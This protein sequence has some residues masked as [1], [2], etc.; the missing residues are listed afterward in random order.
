MKRN[1]YILF[2]V[3]LSVNL[4]AQGGG[5]GFRIGYQ[6]GSFL[7]HMSHLQILSH[8]F[9][10]NYPDASNPL[11]ISPIIHGLVV[12]AYAG[13]KLSFELQWSNKHT[14]DQAE[15]LNSTDNKNI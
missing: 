6:A 4:F 7:R 14:S 2:L 1:V 10:Y 13:N 9:N 11:K 8:Q 12:E 15:F 3:L 5:T